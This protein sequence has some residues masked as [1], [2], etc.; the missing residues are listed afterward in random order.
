MADIDNDG[1][2][3]V[4]I[5]NQG[6]PPLLLKNQTTGGAQ[7]ADRSARAARQ[8]NRFGLGATRRS[9]ARAE[10]ARSREVNNVASYASSNDVRV[11]FGLGQASHQRLTVYWPSGK[12]Q[13]LQN[14]AIDPVRRGRASDA[15]R[16]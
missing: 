16:A 2:L 3:D 13:V 15:Y 5:T 10:H 6:Q 11:H 1:H 8:S 7:L 14:V 4:V 12:V 9:G